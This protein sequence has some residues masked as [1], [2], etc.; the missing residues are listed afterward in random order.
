MFRKRSAVLGVL[1]IAALAAQVS[2]ATIHITRDSLPAGQT[3]TWSASNKYILEGKVFVQGGSK[4]IIPAGTMVLGDIGT[5]AA[6]SMLVVCRDGRL[7]AQG[8]AANPI[9]FTSVL[10]TMG[11]PLPIKNVT[12]GLWGGIYIEGRAPNNNPGG[13]SYSSD[14]TIASADTALYRYGD[15]TNANTHDTSGIIE[16]VS[17]RYCGAS[18]VSTIKGFSVL[19]V[20]DGTVIDHVESFMSAEDG[21][22]LLG[23]NVNIKYLLSAFHA[24]DAVYYDQ[25]YRGKMQ[26]VF[27]IQDTING[28]T[29][30]GC[31]SK[32]EDLDYTGATPVTF[33]QVY[34]ATYIGTGATNKDTWKY[35]YGIYYKKN[36]S[37]K[38]INSILTQCYNYGIYVEDMGTADSVQKYNCRYRLN[39]D[40]LV[41]INDIF[42]GFGKG[43]IIDSITEG[44]PWLKSYI[45]S[46]PNQN[47]ITDPQMGGFGWGRDGLLDPRPSATG[48]ATQHVGTVPNDGFFVQTSYRGAFDPS[49]SL[50]ATGWT[51]FGTTG[52][53]ASGATGVANKNEIRNIASGMQIT[54]RGDLRLLSWS[55]QT[56][57]HVTVKLFSANGKLV[58]TFD[59]G[60]MSAGSH[61]ASISLREIPAGVYVLQANCADLVKSSIV[62]KN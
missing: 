17:I 40:S 26:F 54:G 56:A 55:Q 8:T 36:G 49:A 53:F 28:S 6:A 51:E 60:T 43:N 29:S 7:I 50:W 59:N 5:G 4:L 32:I 61:T 37:G 62:E 23:G 13:V 42:Y 34:N 38:W 2:A 35:K 1:G 14:V 44:M 24:G 46:T 48:V 3:K 33:G 58:R 10:D 15:S 45:D 52:F 21:I 19:S 12:R 20:G 11:V 9:V 22:D 25:G 57:A 39:E 41:I 30:N 16:Y 27:A 31:C 47:D 18:D